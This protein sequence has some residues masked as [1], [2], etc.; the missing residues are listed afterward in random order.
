[1]N[2]NNEELID[3]ADDPDV[4]LNGVSASAAGDGGDG[5]GRNFSGI[6]STGFR[7]F[8]LTPELLR[9]TSDMGFEHP[10]EGLTQ[11]LNPDE[12]LFDNV[13]EDEVEDALKIEQQGDLFPKP[14]LYTNQ[15]AVNRISP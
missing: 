12:L 4:G 7:D 8:Q 13:S 6:H 11:S 15:S 10:S 1:M 14:R 9:D 2:Y 3:Y 5:E